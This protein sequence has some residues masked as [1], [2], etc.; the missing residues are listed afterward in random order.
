MA[1]LSSTVAGRI[2]NISEKKAR[3]RPDFLTA[4][5]LLSRAKLMLKQKLLAEPAGR[6]N[7]IFFAGQT[8]W[9]LRPATIGILKFVKLPIETVLRQQLLMSALFANLAVM[10]DD[11]LVGA[12]DG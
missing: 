9:S 6:L 12:L 4:R 3:A 7:F 8:G 2:V 1:G 11:D 10:H 5:L